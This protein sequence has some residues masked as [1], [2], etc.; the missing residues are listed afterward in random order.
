MVCVQSLEVGRFAHNVLDGI[1]AAGPLD[2][3]G[4]RPLAHAP[5]LHGALAAAAVARHRGAAPVRLARHSAEVLVGG[6]RVGHVDADV[7]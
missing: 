3:P 2:V 1:A 4:E 6:V 7:V 5:L